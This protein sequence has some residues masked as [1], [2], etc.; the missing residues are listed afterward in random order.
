MFYQI[1]YK[2]I[3]QLMLINKMTYF[4]LSKINTV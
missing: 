1:K 2:F 3:D 4:E